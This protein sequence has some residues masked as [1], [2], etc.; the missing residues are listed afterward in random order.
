VASHYEIRVVGRLSEELASS[1][2][3]RAYVQPVETT[4]HG[5]ARDRAE[6]SSLL[7]RLD[8]LGLEVLEFRRTFA[9][10]HGGPHGA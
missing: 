10:A 1:L 8:P 3:L 5:D 6:L 4:L 9:A 2:G 7:D